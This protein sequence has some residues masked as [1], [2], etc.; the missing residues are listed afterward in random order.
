MYMFIPNVRF[1]LVY[2]HVYG[3]IPFTCICPF[4]MHMCVMPCL[5]YYVVL[6]YITSYLYAYVRFILQCALYTDM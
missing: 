1:V 2:M 5:Y 4:H 3:S 6:C